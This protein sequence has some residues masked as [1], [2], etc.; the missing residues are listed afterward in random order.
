MSRQGIDYNKVAKVA[1]SIKKRGIEPS[2]TDICKELGILSITPELTEHIERWYH[3]QPEFKQKNHSPLTGNIQIESSNIIEKNI[4]LEKSLSLL[5]ATLESTADGIMMVNGKGQVVDWNQKFIDMWRIPPSL[6][7]AGTESISFDYILDQLMDPSSLTSDVQYLYQNPS[8]EGELPEVHFK[9]GRIFERYTQPQRVGNEIVG[10]VFSFRDVTQK[11]LAENE[12]HIRERAI[13]A[14]SHGVVIMDILKQGYPVIYVNKAFQKI[15]GYSDKQALGRTLSGLLGRSADDLNCK[16]ITK[17]IQ[18]GEE[19]LIEVESLRQN[20]EL[21]WCELSVAPV[22]DSLGQLHHYICILNDIS[23]R[24]EMEQQLVRQATHD[25]LTE[26]PNRI[27]LLDRVEQ[28]IL[29]AK[30]HNSLLAFLFIDLDRFKMTNDSL[31]HTIGDKLLQVIAN[32]LLIATDESDTVARLGG[33]E[34]V[35]LFTELTS[36]DQVEEKAKEILE[37]VEKPIQIQQHNLKITASLGISYYPQDGKDFETLLKNADLSMYHAKDAGR[38]TYR[39]FEPEMNRKIIN[40]MQLDAA[41]RDALKEKELSLAYQPL[42]DLKRK[43]VVGVE[44]LMRWQSHSLGQ[45]SPID[46]IPMAEENGQ[47]IEM[48]TWA[49]EKACSQVKEWQ[50]KGYKDLTVAVNISGRQFL[51]SDLC[52]IIRSVLQKT[53]LQAKYLE[54]EMT[55]TL[56]IEDLDNIIATMNDLKKMG[57]KLVIDDFGTGYSSLS[58]LKQFPVDKLKIDRSFINEMISD[59]NDAAI[60]K[61]IINLGHSLNLTVLAEGIE[62]EFQLNFITANGCDYAQGYYFLAPQRPEEVSQFLMNFPDKL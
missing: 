26:L 39:A 7:E 18:E 17:A 59:E 55:E 5:R 47:I 60:A 24:R 29:H 30:K 56:L 6:M 57:V 46:F 43:K 12:L 1:E 53:K 10:R 25:S 50:N 36:Y 52:G 51:Q 19:E 15:T 9:D 4:E 22:K 21:F 58:Y 54:L 23:D 45:V 35:I 14:S 8:W 37:S 38:N 2:L 61:A 16:R 27:L 11:R 62:N 40:S 42:I 41:L 48:G 44:A 49:L 31:G 20:G 32:R 33:D 13:E 34:F 28:A 3:N